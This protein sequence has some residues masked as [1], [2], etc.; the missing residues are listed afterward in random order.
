MAKNGIHRFC[1][2]VRVSVNYEVLLFFGGVLMAMA[3]MGAAARA[4]VNQSSAADNVPIRFDLRIQPL[5]GAL[6]IFAELT[7]YSVLVSSALTAGRQAAAVEGLFGPRDA[8]LRLVAGTGLQIR[9]VGAKAFT[10][11]PASSAAHQGTP[12]PGDDRV[13]PD[14][15]SYAADLQSSITRLLCTVQPEAFGRYRLGVQLWFAENGKLRDAR[16]LESSGVKARDAVVLSALRGLEVAALPPDL[17]QPVTILL[18]PRP[19]PAGDCRPYR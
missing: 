4:E 5:E 17:P 3:A 15:S 6:A 12:A 11:V 9:Y 16:L 18:T 1:Q 8:L 10:L 19:D 2:R 7:G 13:A 14:R